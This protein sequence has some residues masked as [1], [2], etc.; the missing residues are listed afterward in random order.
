MSTPGTIERPLCVAVIGSGPSGF[1]AAEALLKAANLTVRV[2]VFDRLPTPFGLVRGGVAPDH[3]KIK[4]VTATYEKVAADPRVRFFGNVKLGRDLSVEDLRA[5]YD[6]IA[7]AAGNRRSQL[8]GGMPH[9]CVQV[10]RGMCR[11]VT[12]ST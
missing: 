3:Q 6:Q 12:R 11:C 1:Y 10:A 2:D 8:R 9:A 7:T 4:A 5:H